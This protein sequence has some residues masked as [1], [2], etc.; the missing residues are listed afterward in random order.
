[1][2]FPLIIMA[3]GMLF[4]LRNL[5]IMYI[6][7][8]WQFWPVILIVIGGS[9]LIS[10]RGAHDVFPGLIIGGIGTIF[11]LRNLGIIYGN[12]WQWIWPL[13]LIAFGAS[14]LIRHMDGGERGPR[15]TA[16]PGVGSTDIP[17]L[18]IDAVFSSAKSM[19]DSQVFT[20]CKVDA[21]F[22]SADIDLRAVGTKLDEVTIKADAVFGEVKIKVSEAWDADVR[23]AGVFGTVEN[24][25][26]K[27]QFV[28]GVTPKRLIVLADA[29]FG[30]VVVKN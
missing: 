6:D 27:P 20:G 15:R 11:L 3:W 29:V 30:S 19:L 23:G 9:K 22:G 8:V 17:F 1:M 2:L 25:T 5:N 13:A 28:G 18:N 16:P 26:R 7:D 21:V 12:V 10:P 14:M 4:L 24:Q